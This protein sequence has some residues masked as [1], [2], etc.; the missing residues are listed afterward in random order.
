MGSLGA[1]QAPHL[2][3]QAELAPGEQSHCLGN[4]SLAGWFMRLVRHGP[5][6]V[7]SES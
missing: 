1:L 2:R 3:V 6:L 5:N 4:V 7:T